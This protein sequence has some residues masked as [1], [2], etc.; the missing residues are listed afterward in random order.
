VK[1]TLIFHF[2]IKRMEIGIILYFAG[3]S[4]YSTPCIDLF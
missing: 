4:V 2:Y 1:N 3:R